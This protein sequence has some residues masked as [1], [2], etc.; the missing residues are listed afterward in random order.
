[1]DVLRAYLNVD[2]CT[3]QTNIKTDIGL[4]FDNYCL[5]NIPDYDLRNHGSNTFTDCLEACATSGADPGQAPCRAVAYNTKDRRCWQKS[6]NGT[7]AELRPTADTIMAFADDS[8]WANAKHTCPYA[9][10]T[11]QTDSNGQ[12]YKIMCGVRY[13]GDNHDPELSEDYLPFHASSIDECL[14]YC[15]KGSPLCYGVLYSEGLDIGYRNCWAK[16][17]NGTDYPD[18]L[19]PDGGAVTAIA[20][21]S[22]NSTCSGT[23]YKSGNGANFETACDMG[24]SGPDLKT[25]HANNFGECMD[26]CANY[27]S[28]GGNSEC[29]NV[30]YQP[31]AQEGFLNCYLKY[32]LD[33][34]TA[35]AQWHLATLMS[36]SDGTSTGETPPSEA[37]P[38]RSQTSGDAAPGSS[39]SSDSGNNNAAVIAGAVAGPV[40]G[41][42]LV[43]GLIFWWRRRRRSSA[44]QPLSGPGDA[45]HHNS[46]TEPFGKGSHPPSPYVTQQSVSSNPK[47]EYYSSYSASAGTSVP[48]TPAQAQP[49]ELGTGRRNTTELPGSDGPRYEMQ[50]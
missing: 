31:S 38:E 43:A 26:E 4:T 44:H 46:E 22:V 33:N 32:A 47:Q 9:N 6:G 21:L 3:N 42:A 19:V 11:I 37:D 15:S 14:N 18:R 34:S 13:K 20:L 7:V 24:G 45:A 50:G 28:N 49:V 8:A 5:T 40:V 1:M 12:Q 16:S 30:I 17:K 2:G 35:Q 25:V 41:I 29:R 48:G 10:G 23:T 27:K 39:S 36:R